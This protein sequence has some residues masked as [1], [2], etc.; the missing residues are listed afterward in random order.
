MSVADLALLPT[1]DRLGLAVHV[2]HVGLA[3]RLWLLSSVCPGVSLPV[4]A[5]AASFLNLR[6]G[7][8]GSLSAVCA[9]P[10][11]AWWESGCGL[12]LE[13]TLLTQGRETLSCSPAHPWGYAGEAPFS[14]TRAQPGS[15][16]APAGSAPQLPSTAP[17]YPCIRPAS[18]GVPLLGLGHSRVSLSFPFSFLW[19]CCPTHPSV[20]GRPSSVLPRRPG[21]SRPCP[22]VVHSCFPSF[23]GAFGVCVWAG[24]R[25]PAG[26]SQDGVD[27]CSQGV[28]G[29][30]RERAMLWVHMVCDI[31]GRCRLSWL[32]QPRAPLGSEG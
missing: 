23:D 3:A 7:V 18:P 13:V 28:R 26:G 12:P 20:W 2:R 10:L 15:T 8:L 6:W 29:H 22:S 17:H 31:W 24:P 9:A 30:G 21:H 14:T 4:L 27:P 16:P 25:S 5:W 11:E 1:R 32:W 19:L